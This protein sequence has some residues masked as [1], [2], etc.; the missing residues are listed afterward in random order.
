MSLCAKVQNLDLKIKT[1]T[2]IDKNMIK[3]KDHMKSVIDKI[4]HIISNI[5]MYGMQW[6]QE[7]LNFE[8]TPCLALNSSLIPTT[9]HKYTCIFAYNF[10]I[11]HP[12]FSNE[13]Q[14]NYVWYSHTKCTHA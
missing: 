5:T 2:N 3:V 14:E 13:Y 7:I 10:F 9:F 1:I 12:S 4:S 11:V 8:Y 6:Y